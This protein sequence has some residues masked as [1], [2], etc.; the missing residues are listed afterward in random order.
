M[1]HEIQDIVDH[2]NTIRAL[3]RRSNQADMEDSG[4]T[5]QQANALEV[6]SSENGLA[7]TELSERTTLSHRT[8]SDIVDRLEGKNL[9]HR[10]INSK[11]RRYAH[12]FLDEN[13]T[14]YFNYHI[15]SQR[16]NLMVGALR[17]ATPTE[18]KIIQE[19]LATPSA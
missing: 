3:L 9:L 14:G 11:E 19:G 7:L 13:V 2:F 15:P 5:F 10:H 4:L 16:T 17:R 8:V 12:I 1:M 6:L 18:R